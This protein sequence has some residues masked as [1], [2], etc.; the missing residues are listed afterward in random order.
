MAAY[1]VKFIRLIFQ[2]EQHWAEALRVHELA[3][4]VTDHPQLGVLLINSKSYTRFAGRIIV[5]G[6][7]MAAPW[8]V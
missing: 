2:V 1:I 5:F 7:R 8:S 6:K 3:P 4:M